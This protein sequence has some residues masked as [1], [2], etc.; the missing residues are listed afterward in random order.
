MPTA[1]VR[2]RT[3]RVS[4]KGAVTHTH[5]KT[6]ESLSDFASHA[7]EMLAKHGGPLSSWTTQASAFNNNTS[8]TDAED[9]A[10]NGWDKHLDDVLRIAEEAIE[11]CET[12]HQIIKPEMRYDVTGDSVDIG[13]YLA[14]EPECMM[15]YPLVPVSAVGKV[16]TLCASVCYSAA[17]TADQML[18]RGQVIT[19]LALA[20][21]QVG[22]QV[23]LWADM[24]SRC[25]AG[26]SLHRRVLI[27]RTRVLVKGAH[28]LLE[29]S[30]IA[31]AYAHPA[32][33]R[34]LLLAVEDD[35]ST[36]PEFRGFGSW[37]PPCSPEQDLPDGTIYLP[38]LKASESQ[39]EAAEMLRQYLSQL[40]LLA[41]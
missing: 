2:T 26:D 10:L 4:S 14:G 34:Q 37:A 21:T 24:S 9:L 15:D 1:K 38:E 25:A 36:D 23:E 3:R 17:V 29:P 16:I 31:F 32:M 40:G 41:D 5:Q 6:Y 28:D 19:A 22:H 35:V 33:L 20:L 8:F 13:R 39:P 11:L 12:R 27:S 30:K 18:A 7:S